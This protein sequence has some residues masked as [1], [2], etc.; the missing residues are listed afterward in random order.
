[1]SMRAPAAQAAPARVAAPA[2]RPKRTPNEQPSRVLRLVRPGELTPRARQ[3]RARMAA[4]FTVVLVAMGLFATVVFHVVLTQ[5]QFKLD[6][7]SN[8]A[9]AEQARYQRLRLQVAEL[10]SPDRIVATAQ[11]KLGMVQPAKVTYLAPVAP[12]P[13]TVGGTTDA[14]DH[15]PADQRASR[16]GWSNVKPQL[17]AHP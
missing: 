4:A 10:E 11:Q 12:A 2:P 1:M 13:T 14:A 16:N 5:N 15:T 17:T 3:R 7:L 9:T 8:Q 6:R